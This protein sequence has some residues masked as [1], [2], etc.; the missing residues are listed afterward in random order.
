MNKKTKLWGLVVILVIALV[1]LIVYFPTETNAETIKIGFIGPLTGD[2]AVYGTPGRNMVELVVEEV[3]KE[4]GIDGK[5]IEVIYEDGKCNGKDAANAVQKLVNIDKVEVVIGG[6]CS[7]ESLGAEPIATQ[8]RV[9]LFSLGSSSPDLTGKSNF[10][11]RD[12]PSDATQGN[13]LANLANEK[14]W[15]KVVFIQ[16][17][18]D[19]PL[20]I[21]NAFTSEF[22]RLGGSVVKEEFSSDTSDFRSILV[23]LKSENP[24]VLF[25]DTQTPATAERILKQLNEL[26]WKPQIFVSDA[27]SGDTETV[28]RNSDILE[29]AYAAEF[30]TD[31]SNPK[32]KK[33][34]LV[35]K[36]KYGEEPPFLSYAQTEYDGAYLLIDAIQSVGYDGEKIANYIMNVKGWEGASGSITIGQN[37]DRIGGHIPKVI[38][39]GE[40]LKL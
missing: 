37:G 17:Q 30:G 10:F 33:M 8:N 5:Q 28:K 40:V 27:V 1:A 22:E 20:G 29:G 38:R 12:Y 35:Y 18:Q 23:K 6:F 4:G 34:V 21:Y 7:S 19:Y 11:A 32:F 2:A 25:V 36:N 9:F 15:N 26:N 24:D 13:V 14:R 39:D 3:N 16:E 31:E